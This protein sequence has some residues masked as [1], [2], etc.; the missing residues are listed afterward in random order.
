MSRYQ[1]RST[2]NLVVLFIVIAIIIAGAFSAVRA[3]FFSGNSTPSQVDTSKT[4]LLNTSAGQSVDM[5]VRGPIVANN[6]HN[7]YR[8]LISPSGNELTT[9][10]GYQGTIL[11]S[12]SAPNN[13]QAYEQ[14]V[15]A[16]E[17]LG[18]ANGTEYTGE[19]NDT[20]GRCASGRVYYFSIN[21]DG[22]PI[23]T[24]WKTS[25]ANEGSFRGEFNSV[26]NLFY[27]QFSSSA[28]NLLNG[29]NI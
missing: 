13:S 6:Q 21:K 26:K 17:R 15:N 9:Y 27:G 29:I 3:I 25:C 18:Y 14:F 16:L 12:N 23:K 10:V 1:K 24:L 19:R 20:L 5:Y 7:S 8:M 2:L 4:E 22:Q 11:A 28:T